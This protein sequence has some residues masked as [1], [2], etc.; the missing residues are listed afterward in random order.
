[1]GGAA[2]SFLL[3][4]A[5]GRDLVVHLAGESLLERVEG[6]LERHG[7]WNLVRVRFI[8]IPFALV[9]FGAALAGY[10]LPQFLIAS[11]L[12]LAPSLLLYTYFGHALFTVATADRQAVLRNLFVALFLILLLTFLVPLRRAWKRRRYR[13]RKESD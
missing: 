7:F 11:V 5:L 6:L 4:R 10:P 8:P 12:G 9:N 1:M 13:S 2:A 3:A